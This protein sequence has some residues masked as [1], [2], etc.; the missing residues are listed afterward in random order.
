[1]SKLN[2]D[3]SLINSCIQSSG[4]Y[5]I[6]GGANTLI[7]A[8]MQLRWTAGVFYTP[9]ITINGMKY[10]GALTC[11]G[12][13][14]STCSLLQALCAGFADDSVPAAC[15]VSSICDLGQPIDAC[16]SCGTQVQD[17]CGTCFAAVANPEKLPQWNQYCAGCDGKPNS[18]AQFDECGFCQGPG[19]D[20]CGTCLPPGDANRI[21]KNSSRSC[22]DREGGFE[23]PDPADGFPVWATVFIVVVILFGVGIGVTVVV[24]R[25]EARVR[26]DVDALLKQYMPM[27]T[28]GERAEGTE[29]KEAGSGAPDELG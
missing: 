16:G 22:N 17:E 21:E 8:E 28:R 15:N 7:D 23:V 1:M 27:E 26:A 29:T 9:T 3:V 10:Q 24:N 2:I 4:G 5:E 6:T 19:K 11:L 18:G 25:R 20:K 12:F 14:R 13:R